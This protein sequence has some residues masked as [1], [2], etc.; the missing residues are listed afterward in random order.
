MITTFLI[1]SLI[2]FTLS[3]SINLLAIGFSIGSGDMKPE[4]ANIIG[5]IIYLCMISFNIIAIASI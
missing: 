4:A 2:V 3:L 5:A 1:A